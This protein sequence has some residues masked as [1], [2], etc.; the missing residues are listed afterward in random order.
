KLGRDEKMVAVRSNKEMELTPALTPIAPYKPHPTTKILS[1]AARRRGGWMAVRGAGA[2]G[3]QAANYR[4]PWP[5]LAF[6]GQPIGRRL[7]AAAA[8]TRLGRRPQRRD[9]VSLGGGTQRT[10]RRDRRRVRPGI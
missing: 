4:V 10:L 6:G 9:R 1:H 7:C 2:A 3:G 8:R 5:D